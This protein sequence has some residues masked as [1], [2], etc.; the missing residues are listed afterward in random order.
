MTPLVSI[1]VTTYCHEAYLRQTLDS[2]LAQQVRFP[3]EILIHDDCS[4]D[5]TVAIIREYAQ[6]YPEIVLPLY[7]TENQYSQNI[8]INE[9]F[10]FPRARGKYIALCEGDEVEAVYAYC[11]LHSLWK[12]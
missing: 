3:F 2:L 4:P 6:K 12:A 7:E 10:N 1:C 9:T 11:N 8:P 5:G